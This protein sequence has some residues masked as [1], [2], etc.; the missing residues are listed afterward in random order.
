MQGPIGPLWWEI[1]WA[2]S[3]KG[4]SKLTAC[5]TGGAG[6]RRGSASVSSCSPGGRFPQGLGTREMCHIEKNVPGRA[7]MFIIPS[8]SMT[9]LGRSQPKKAA[10]YL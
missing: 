6:T 5:R 2:H 9:L 7:D 3:Q 10:S 8:S 4:L 1:S